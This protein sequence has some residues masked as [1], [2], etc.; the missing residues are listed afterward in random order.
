MRT[1]PHPRVCCLLRVYDVKEVRDCSMTRS[2]TTGS[3]MATTRRSKSTLGSTSQSL[4]ATATSAA[5]YR[6]DV[7]ACVRLQNCVDMSI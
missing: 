7:R 4:D 5:R 3:S 2:S 6:E 1:G